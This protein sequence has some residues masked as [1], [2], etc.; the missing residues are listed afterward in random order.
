[1][2]MP[3]NTIRA[4][5]NKSQTRRKATKTKSATRKTQKSNKGKGVNK[6]ILQMW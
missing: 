1:L 3:K 5:S 2:T 4:I 6:P